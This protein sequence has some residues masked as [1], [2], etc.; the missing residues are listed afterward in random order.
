M[1]SDSPNPPPPAPPV[2]Q[3]VRRGPLYQGEVNPTGTDAPTPASK[4]LVSRSFYWTMLIALVGAA[5]LAIWISPDL[6]E[7]EPR[8]LTQPA[9][10]IASDVPIAAAPLDPSLASAYG[11][12][13]VRQAGREA[14][15]IG[16]A[17][18]QAVTCEL[19]PRR[20]GTELR[21]ATSADITERYPSFDDNDMRG[22]A[23]LSQFALEQFDIGQREGEQDLA[24]RGQQQVCA[25][26]P[27]LPDYRAADRL[28]RDVAARRQ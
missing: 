5:A 6:M 28:A 14:R 2:Y 23:L 17:G 25:E 21:A 3:S 12:G 7:P 9:T 19:K 8:V 22:R 11:E 26:L 4:R 13:T 20:W 15:R 16:K 18:M 10:P 1:P 27:T 24:Q